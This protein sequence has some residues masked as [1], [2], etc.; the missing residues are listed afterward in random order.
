MKPIAPER[1][2]VELIWCADQGAS[3]ADALLETAGERVVVVESG[4]VI[5]VPVRTG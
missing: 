1:F 5:I 3:V 2:R 4:P